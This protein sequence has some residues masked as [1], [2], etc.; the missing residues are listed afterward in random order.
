MNSSAAMELS[1]VGSDHGGKHP[2]SALLQ[3]SALQLQSALHDQLRCVSLGS[4]K[5]LSR[6]AAA[7][8]LAWHQPQQ[9]SG[10]TRGT[11]DTNNQDSAPTTITD[12]SSSNLHSYQVTTCRAIHSVVVGTNAQK[13]TTAAAIA[14]G[15][16]NLVVVDEDSDAVPCTGTLTIAM[17]LAFAVG[18]ALVA[19]YIWMILVYFLYC[20]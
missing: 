17:D 14:T 10:N 5:G 18:S 3:A 4:I 13:N 19:H 7:Q 2:D 8:L 20:F 1:L 9:Q 15:E 12:N 6:P 11:E 16:K